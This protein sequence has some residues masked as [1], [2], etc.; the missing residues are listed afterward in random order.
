MRK[1]A[2]LTLL[3]LVWDACRRVRGWWRR[4]TFFRPISNGR[5]GWRLNTVQAAAALAFLS[6]VQA[7]VLPILREVVPPEWW[8]YVTGGVGLLII[9][10]RLRDQPG[11]DVGRSPA[12]EPGPEGNA[13]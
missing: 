9:L 1:S 12:A 10:L 3:M 6:A 5:Q 7:D 8:P 2:T 4:T 11:V 13:P